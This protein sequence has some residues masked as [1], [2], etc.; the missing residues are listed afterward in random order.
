MIYG[1]SKPYHKV[2][3]IAGYTL[4]YNSYGLTLTAHEPFESA[5]QVIQNGKD[6]VSNQV[7]VQHAFNRILVGDTDNGKKLKENIAD[8]KELYR[9]VQT[10][11]YKRT[12]KIK[13]HY[14]IS[15]S[16][17][18]RLGFGYFS[19]LFSTRFLNS[20][21]LSSVFTPVPRSRIFCC[22]SAES[23]LK[24]C[25]ASTFDEIS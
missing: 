11:Y 12:R 18:N 24:Y 20:F 23:E 21:S 15:T 8:L 3:G 5:E 7:A 22:I 4:T 16:S 2:T 17:Q 1:F 14:K 9:G 6:I 13:H 25:V 10:R 19:P